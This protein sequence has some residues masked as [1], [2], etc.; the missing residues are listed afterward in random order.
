MTHRLN[1]IPIA[2]IL[3]VFCWACNKATIDSPKPNIILFL[4]DDMG[5]MDTSV[6]MLTDSLGNPQR[7]PLN[8]WFQTPNMEKLA[9]QGMRFSNF[10]AHTVCSPS[11]I[12]IMT[13]QNSARHQTTNW[14]NPYENNGDYLDPPQWKWTGLTDQ[15]VT[16]PALLK[17]IGYQTIFIGKAHFGPFE[18]TGVNPLNLGFD[19]NIAGTGI[20]RPGSYYGVDG[21]GH[22]NGEKSRAVPDLEKYH[23]QDIFLTEAL[24]LEAISQIDSSLLEG[25]PF[26]LYTAHYAVH[27]PFQP[28][29]RF[30]DH[31]QDTS[32]S[33]NSI[34]FATMIEGM[35]KSLGDLM[36]HLESKG[37]ADNTLILFLGDNGSDSPF[38][39]NDDIAS[40]S[41]LRGKKGSKWEGG[42]RT[43]FIAAW[44]KANKDIFWQQ[45][46][47]IQK[48]KMID[49]IGACYDL[50]P[51]ITELLNLPVPE[52]YKVDG[53]SLSKLLVGNKDLERKDEFLSHFPHSREDK[54]FTT[55]REGDWKLI[56]HYMP[57]LNNRNSHF[58]L[59][60]LKS[61]RS[62]SHDVSEIF[63]EVVKELMNKMV[64]DLEAKN[65]LY[66]TDSLGNVLR[67][68]Y[69]Q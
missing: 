56:Y 1:R 32:V 7:H 16:L 49:N 40:S 35:D 50:F 22:I 23:G 6:P 66:P 58:E 38:G 10:Y 26:F 54:Y 48:S 25:K 63:P 45:K 39:G 64:N 34:S 37:I 33:E 28:D 4:V 12:A 8:D 69:S 60:N 19:V 43:P 42:I 14:I 24:T 59:Y 46:L 15:D 41:P 20:G 29:P 52:G 2:F 65:A 36:D 3:M 51:T 18:H 67:P 13:G 47:P 31:Y 57:K 17:N 11:R 9:N 27:S 21:F 44:A 5:L 55:Y 68:V 30:I 62:E 61:D 53:K